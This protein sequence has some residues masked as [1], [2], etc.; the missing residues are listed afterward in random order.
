MAKYVITGNPEEISQSSKEPTSV[1]GKIGRYI[2][3]QTRTAVSNIPYIGERF[4]EG[5][6]GLLTGG[7]IAGGVTDIGSMLAKGL[8]NVLP[9]HSRERLDR[10]AGGSVEE[11]IPTYSDIQK[12]IPSVPQ[13]LKALQDYINRVNEE[14]SVAPGYTFREPQKPEPVD[15]EKYGKYVNFPIVGATSEQLRKGSAEPFKKDYG[16]EQMFNPT[17]KWAERVGNVAEDLPL[18]LDP[19]NMTKKG[20]GRALGK[21]IT[22]NAAQTLAD[23]L[24]QSPSTGQAL[25]MGTYLLMSIPENMHKMEEMKANNYKIWGEVTEAAPQKGAITASIKQDLAHLKQE[26]SRGDIGREE[27]ILM[28]ELIDR[29]EKLIEP[30][31]G[32]I[33]IREA[34]EFKKDTNKYIKDGKT[35]YDAKTNYLPR[36]VEMQKQVIKDWGHKYAKKAW[37]QYETAD[38]I[39]QGQSQFAY[40]NKRLDNA[41]KNKPNS[42]HFAAS[43]ITNTPKYAADIARLITTNKG[44]RK[45]YID[46]FKSTVKDNDKALYKSLDYL[47]RETKKLTEKKS[48]TYTIG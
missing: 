23:E 19:A 18:F 3:E 24:G 17:G 30:E 39:H 9:A 44:F 28:R 31:T 16:L 45:A 10:L 26:V 25:K 48:H 21:T 40:A 13:G 1:P 4:A 29:Y 47:D 43:I 2:G 7:T 32:K 36:F 27:K 8:Y 5:V 14:Y 22:G 42:W 46:V 20:L 41:L 37:K 6:G 34:T 33:D 12:Y 35:P 11:M 38:L 15:L